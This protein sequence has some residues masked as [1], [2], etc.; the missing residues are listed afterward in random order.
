MMQTQRNTQ[1]CPKCGAENSATARFCTECK[2]KLSRQSLPEST[3]NDV[4]TNKLDQTSGIP[5]LAALGLVDDVYK[6]DEADMITR[7]LDSFAEDDQT[8]GDGAVRLEGNLILTEHESGHRYEI[9]HDEL[10]EAVI[11][12][13]SK[14]NN[15]NPIIDLKPLEAHK[16]GVSRRHATISFRDNW[17]VIVDHNSTNGTYINGRRLVPE[18]ARVIR[19]NDTIRVGA[20]LLHVSYGS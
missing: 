3:E 12:R 7:H 2:G 20:I 4:V 15:F 10:K 13:S 6:L 17:I 16:Y 19:D 8:M 9:T 11:G 5:D 1:V 18:Q 14:K